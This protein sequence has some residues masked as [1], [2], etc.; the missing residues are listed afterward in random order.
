MNSRN[1]NERVKSDLLSH[2][3]DDVLAESYRLKD[4]FSH[5]W[6]YPSRIKYDEAFKGYL[7]NLSGKTVLD[8]GCGRGQASLEYLRQG[9]HVHGIDIYHRPT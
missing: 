6:T 3:E 2:T 9:A 8:Y 7:A 5:I 4:R 1:I